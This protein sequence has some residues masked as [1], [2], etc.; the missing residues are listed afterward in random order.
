M[1]TNPHPYRP[2][3]PEDP[4]RRRDSRC[5]GGGLATGAPT[6]LGFEDSAREVPTVT[7][8]ASVTAAAVRVL[9]PLLRL[10]TPSRKPIFGS[11]NAFRAFG[12]A[13]DYVMLTRIGAFGAGGGAT[14]SG[15]GSRR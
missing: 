14:T 15:E 1:L 7:S 8:P 13:R 12:F 11:L 10:Q 6:V 5:P 9:E 3:T 2:A 4:G